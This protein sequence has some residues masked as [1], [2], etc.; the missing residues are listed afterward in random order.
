MQVTE[1]SAEGLK[2][3]FKIVVP[4]SD[5]ST[6]VEERLAELAKTAQ[7]PGFRQGKVPVALLKKQYGQALFGEALEQAVNDGTSKAIEDRGL[8]PAV[9]PRVELKQLEEGKDVEFEVAVEVLPEIGKLDFSNVE[10]ERLKAA[11]PDKDVDDALDRIANDGLR[12]LGS[13]GCSYG[14]DAVPRCRR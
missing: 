10:L 1:L 8:K 13:E 11:V 2:R 4:A 7:M 12:G 3:Q 9:Q 6:K 5:L 14:G